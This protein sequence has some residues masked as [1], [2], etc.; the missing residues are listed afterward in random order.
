MNVQTT[1][2]GQEGLEPV[3]STELSSIISKLKSKIRNTTPATL[4]MDPESERCP[5]VIKV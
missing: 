3:E 4:E 1:V 2:S 5:S